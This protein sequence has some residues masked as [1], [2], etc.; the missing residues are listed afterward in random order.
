MTAMSIQQQ[1]DDLHGLIEG[2]RSLIADGR[3]VDIS[4]VEQKMT[5]LFDTVSE[6]PQASLNVDVGKLADSLAHLMGE[7]DNLE[8]DL[9]QQHESLKAE[10]TVAPNSAAAA[11]Q[12]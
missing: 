2:S 10:D 6:N 7:L 5:R 12:S 1:A 11:Y 9:T 8:A 3:F 4:E